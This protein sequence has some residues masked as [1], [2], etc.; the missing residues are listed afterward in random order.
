[1]FSFITSFAITLPETAISDILAS[2]SGIF[3]D[4]SPIIFLVLGV[5]V[6]FAI[7]FPLMKILLYWGS[8]QVFGGRYRLWPV[9]ENEPDEYEEDE[10]DEF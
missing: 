6:A 2:V 10:E 4:L 5:Y 9:D 7:V 8:R 3:T 1:M